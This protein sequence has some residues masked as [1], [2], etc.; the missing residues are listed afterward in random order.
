MDSVSCHAHRQAYVLDVLPLLLQ[1]WGEWRQWVNPVVAETTPDKSYSSLESHKIKI[2]HKS[3]CIYKELGCLDPTTQGEAGSWQTWEWFSDNGVVHFYREGKGEH[4]KYCLNTSLHIWPKLRLECAPIDVSE[5]FIIGFPGS[6]I[7]S[8]VYVK[9]AD[10]SSSLFI[11]FPCGPS[12]SSLSSSIS[13]TGVVPVLCLWVRC[14]RL[15]LEKMWSEAQK[16]CDAVSSR[17]H[18]RGL[19]GSAC[20]F[21]DQNWQTTVVILSGI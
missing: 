3:V 12:H 4:K 14:G 9:C 7:V 8:P 11:R 19:T 2:M 20:L 15:P 6:R 5:C 16:V 18:R 17:L 13:A 1:I 21:A 10:Y